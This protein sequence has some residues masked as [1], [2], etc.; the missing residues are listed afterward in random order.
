MHSFLGVYI[1]F[2]TRRSDKWRH[3]KVLFLMQGP[4]RLQMRVQIWY[5]CCQ[6]YRQINPKLNPN[7]QN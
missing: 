1:I 4:R 2:I 3:L 6:K 5:K 7:P